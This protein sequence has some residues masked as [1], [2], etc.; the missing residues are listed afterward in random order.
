MKHLLTFRSAVL[1]AVPLLIHGFAASGTEP[2]V[3]TRQVVEGNTA[4]AT[5]LY[6][7]LKDQAGNLFF[8]PYSIST[9]LAMTSAGAR[10]STAEQMAK[11]LH[12]EATQERLH[13]AFAAL[14]SGLDAVQ[15][16]GK[17]QL[18]VANS[19]WPHKDYAFRPEFIDLLKKFYGAT[20]TP[21]DYAGAT[22]TARRTIND[23]VET[24]T[25]HKIIDLLKPG[26]LD[27]STRLVLANAIY[28]K[29]NWAAQFEPKAT[30]DQPFRVAPDKEVKTPLMTH[31]GKFRYAES[32]D[33]R[34]WNCRTPVTICR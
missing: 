29:G 25:K 24:K 9:A 28:F 17:V 23:W 5:D 31:K 1:A 15:R 20:V 22:E 6:A 30:S 8:S 33:C 14:E 7:R 16:K 3:D 26:V 13:P 34:C 4:L 32:P 12:F 2:S 21:L 18:S 27:K 19:L 11:A 10:G